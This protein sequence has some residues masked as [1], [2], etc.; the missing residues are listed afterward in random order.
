MA[1][2]YDYSWFILDQSI[3]KREFALSGSEQN[4]DLTGKSWRLVLRRALGRKAAGPVEAF[5]ARGPDFVVRDT[6]ADLV[7]GMNALAG[8]ARLDPAA[9]ERVLLDRDDAIDGPPDVATRSSPR[10]VMPAL[11]SPTGSSGSQSPT[12]S[13]IR[14]TD[15]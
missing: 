15:P 8:E 9:I 12:A 2:G 1:T 13:S 10:S 5:K 11:T 4:P 6:L 3:V 14:R 7:A